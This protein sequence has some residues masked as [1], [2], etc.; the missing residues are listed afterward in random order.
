MS[1]RDPRVSVVIV[2]HN[3]E[4]YL[5]D[6][7]LS[8]LGQAY[9][10]LEVVIVDDGSTDG[11][12][13]IIAEYRDRV[14]LVLQHNQGPAA[15]YNAGYA[16]TDGELVMFLDADDMLRPTAVAE[17][18]A[19][20]RPE[21]AKLQF[22]LEIIDAAGCSRGAFEPVYPAAYTAE[23]L[24]EEFAATASYVWPP[25]AGNAFSRAFLRQVMPLSPARFHF[26]D[27]AL[28]TVAPLFGEVRTLAKPLGLYRIHGGNLWALQRFCETRIESYVVQRRHEIDYL[29]ELAA[30][31]GVILPPGD[32]LDHSLTFLRYRLVAAKRRGASL[33]E[34]LGLC[35]R[36]GRCLPRANLSPARGT[37][38]LLWFV[39]VAFSRGAM[40]R[41]LIEWRFDHRRRR[42]IARLALRGYRRAAR[43]VP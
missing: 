15:A 11:S 30:E 2:N 23:R 16:A 34:L 14:R 38:E 35:R 24:R 37:A 40:A 32:P 7:I 19:A 22:S 25:T 43:G 39:L 31:R 42:W 12:R 8:V 17:V 28:S 10:H 36:A 13:A 4:R 18:A 3:Y 9:R 27:G 6:A 1:A 29:R 20:W 41:R 5:R 21:V 26:I 33:V